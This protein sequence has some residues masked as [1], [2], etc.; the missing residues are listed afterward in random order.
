LWGKLMRCSGIKARY[1][2]SDADEKVDGGA[3]NDILLGGAQEDTLD[4]GDGNDI[5]KGGAGVDVYTLHSVYGTDVI[6]DSDGQG[7]IT[8]N[9]VALTG[10]TFKFDNIYTHTD[11]GT[12]TDTIY[13]KLNDGTSIVISK[14]NDPNR[15]IINDWSETNN[16]SIN[17][18]G[19]APAAPQATLTGDFKKAIDTHG[20]GDTSDDTYILSQDGS[21]NY[22]A[23]PNAPDG[24]TNALD[25]ISG[26]ASDDVI[27]GGGVYKAVIILWRLITN[28]G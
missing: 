22:T 25:L 2:A 26:T 8:V 18:T 27:D 6:T 23:D 10:A 21:N 19:S 5:L 12:N 24:E 16:L 17:L 9:D 14:E 1:L 20:T 28:G 4:G 15:I 13:T 7:I 11:L 3:G